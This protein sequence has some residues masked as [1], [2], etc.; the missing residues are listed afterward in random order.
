MNAS[1]SGTVS[2]WRAA[3]KRLAA[4]VVVRRAVA[5]FALIVIGVLVALWVSNWNA[6]RDRASTERVLL[7]SIRGALRSDLVLLTQADSGYR[8]REQRVAALAD[9]LRRRAPYTD[10]LH[11]AFG[12]VFG[13]WSVKVNRAPYEALKAMDFSL[14]GSDSLR[15]ALADLY[16][17]TYADLEQEEAI[18]R[19]AIFDVL[20]PYY[21]RSFRDLRFRESATPIDPA[22]VMA[23]PYYRNLVEYRLAVLRANPL[24]GTA[25]AIAQVKQTIA[26][27]DRS[28]AAER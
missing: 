24:A 21:L 1:T 4:H 27:I 5:E 13:L 12:A 18:D 14:I 16:E 11:T 23:D 15:A 10:S 2:T 3:G 7:A 19:N 22:A 8:A 17:R 20:R 26:L 9:H 25:Q 6:R 28:V